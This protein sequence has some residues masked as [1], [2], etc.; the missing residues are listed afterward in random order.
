M[1][2]IGHYACEESD[3]PRAA[4]GRTYPALGLIGMNCFDNQL[5]STQVLIHEFGHLFY[6]PDHYGGDAPYSNDLNEEWGENLFNGDCVYG[7]YR[8]ALVNKETLP[9]CE[10]C[11]RC[12]EA[13]ITAFY[14]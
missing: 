12:I 10:G 14:N 6:A 9:V 3:H 13:G 4:L 7:E 1:L 5:E 11:R 8:F 2:Y